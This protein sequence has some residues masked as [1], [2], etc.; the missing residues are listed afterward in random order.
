M[1]IWNS[2]T[3]GYRAWGVAWF[4][5][6]TLG[7]WSFSHRDQQGAGDPGNG[8]ASWSNDGKMAGRQVKFQ[9][10]RWCFAMAT[11]QS[12]YKEPFNGILAVWLDT[13]Q[14]IRCR[15][16]RIGALLKKKILYQPGTLETWASPTLNEFWLFLMDFSNTPGWQV[17]GQRWNLGVTVGGRNPEP[18]EVGSLSHSLQGFWHPRWLFGISEPSTIHTSNGF[19]K[20]VCTRTGVP[21]VDALMRELFETGFMANRGRASALRHQHCFG[22]LIPCLPVCMHSHQ[23]GSVIMRYASIYEKL[24]LWKVR[25][26][27]LIKKWVNHATPRETVYNKHQQR[28]TSFLLCHQATL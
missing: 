8:I 11:M 23:Q 17:M 28:E 26:L 13:T 4:Q 25:W 15:I 22:M 9:Q 21:L 7:V 18:V 27:S 12:T 16:C 1:M 3:L 2:P 24:G 19:W 6:L 20:P 14:Q 10:F 5:V